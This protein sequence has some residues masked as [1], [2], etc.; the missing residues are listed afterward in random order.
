MVF[1]GILWLWLLR[2]QVARQSHLIEIQTEERTLIEERQRIARELHDTLEQQLAGVRY[3]LNALNKWSD[4]APPSVGRAV[5]ATRAML[6][7][8]REEMRRSVFELRSPILE[9]QGLVA[10]IRLTLETISPSGV[11]QI[12]VIVEGS[13][14]RLPRRVE[15]HLMRVVQ[16]A[17]T[18]AVKHA[19]ASEVTV[20]FR[21]SE[22]DLEIVIQ[23]NGRG[24]DQSDSKHLGANR[25]GMLGIRERLTKIGATME[26]KSIPSQGTALTLTFRE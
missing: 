24:F 22:T 11:P 4:E 18:N 10:A 15:F 2:R 7:H 5:A 8:S 13:E 9:Q 20:T 25:F 6:D 19:E 3:H 26:M 14:R 12:S 17:L 1:F 21:F 23:D 16:E